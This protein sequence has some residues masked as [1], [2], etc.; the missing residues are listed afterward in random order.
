[1]Y[2]SV[3]DEN[4][5]VRNSMEVDCGSTFSTKEMNQSFASVGNQTDLEYDF[6]LSDSTLA[7]IQQSMTRDAQAQQILVDVLGDYLQA[8]IKW[9]ESCFQPREL[10]S[11]FH[12]DPVGFTASYYVQRMAKHSGASPCCFVAAL[13]YLE[14][15]CTRR[16]GLRLTARTLRR[17]LLVAAMEAVKYLEDEPIAN[18]R[19]ASIGGLCLQELNALELEF[20]F[21][22]DFDLA[23]RPADYR[24][25]SGALRAFGRARGP[26]A[27]ARCSG[28]GE[29]GEEGHG[30]AAAAKVRLGLAGASAPMGRP[31][32]SSPPPPGGPESA[33]SP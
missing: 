18:Q 27:G 15:I 11:S 7:D 24:G 13:I 16:P 6:H 23:V 29:V 8:L 31:A 17:L 1:M 20:L 21:A 14:R 12:G 4:D 9:N 30:D 32:Q 5:H 33:A 19:W 10:M 22:I 26:L 28:L 2:L 3:Y 25:C